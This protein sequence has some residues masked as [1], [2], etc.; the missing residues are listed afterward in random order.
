MKW[1][2]MYF[3]MVVDSGR[4]IWYNSGIDDAVKGADRWKTKR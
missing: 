4:A 2:T 3:Q 1:Y